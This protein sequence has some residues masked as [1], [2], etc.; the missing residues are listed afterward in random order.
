MTLWENKGAREEWGYGQAVWEELSQVLLEET[1]RNSQVSRVRMFVG[2]VPAQD[3]ECSVG[4]LYL[5]TDVK[6]DATEVTVQPLQRQALAE[7]SQQR[8]LEPEELNEL[9][10]A[11]GPGVDG[12]QV[13]ESRVSPW[14]GA[15]I[16]TSSGGISRESPGAVFD[17]DSK[18]DPGSAQT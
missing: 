5:T 9:N 10:G 12:R 15:P 13:D 8:E 14:A 2:T 1:S 16:E 6:P 18:P 3:A 17:P 7:K 4:M 11:G